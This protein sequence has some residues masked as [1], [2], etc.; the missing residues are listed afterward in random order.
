MSIDL[1]ILYGIISKEQLIFL[2]LVP[3]LH[4]VCHALPSTFLLKMTMSFPTS[5]KFCKLDTSVI[6][7]QCNG[8]AVEM[9]HLMSL[10][11]FPFWKFEQQGACNFSLWSWGSFVHIRHELIDILGNYLAMVRQAIQDMVHRCQ[12]CIEIRWMC[13]RCGCIKEIGHWY[14]YWVRV[15]EG[16]MQKC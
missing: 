14:W 15:Q 9:F 16:R 7:K 11:S 4:H 12:I 6:A 2:P 3:F 5:C 1:N 8:V 13:C 10:W